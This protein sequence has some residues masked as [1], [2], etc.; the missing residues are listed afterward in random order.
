[1]PELGPGV[2]LVEATMTE[3]NNVFAKEYRFDIDGQPFQ[4]D[5][6][7]LDGQVITVAFAHT[8][9]IFRTKQ[10]VNNR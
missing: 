5:G 6:P 1:M 9:K 4:L 2:T 7:L 10:L 3:H 8:L